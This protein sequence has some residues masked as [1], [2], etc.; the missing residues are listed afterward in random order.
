M[1]VSLAVVVWLLGEQTGF[2]PSNILQRLEWIAYDERVN[3]TLDGVKDEGVVIVDIDESSIQRI[4]HWP[5][6]R[7]TLAELTHKLFNDYDIQLLGLDMVFAEREGDALEER[8]QALVREFPQLPDRPTV[9]AGDDLFAE[10]LMN[11][12]VVTGF[13]FQQSASSL[14]STGLLSEPLMVLNA[15]EDYLQIPFLKPSRYT[16]NIETLQAGAWA[17]GFFDNPMVDNDGVIRRAPLVQLYEGELYPSLPLAMLG[18]VL[19]FPPVE[20]DIIE[21]GG[22]LQ[23]EGID[24]GGFYFPTD[25]RGG[26]LVPWSGP[27]EHYTYVSAADVLSGDADTDILNDAIV[28]LGTSAPGLMDLRSTPVGGVYPGV[29][30]QANLLS[31]MLQ[32]NFKQ[33]PGYS[34]AI[35]AL[36]ILAFGLLFTFLYPRFRA[37]AILVVSGLLLSLHLWLNLYAWNGG[38]VLPLASG[39]LLIVLLTGWHLAMNFLRESAEKRQVAEQFG[40]YI[41]PEL[42]SDIVK[43][44]EAQDMVGQEKELTVLFSD[45]RGFTSF[46]EQIPPAEL[47]DVMNRLLTP[48]TQAIHANRGTIDKYMGDAVMAFWGAPLDDPDHPLHAV[49]GALAMQDALDQINREFEAEG[50]QRLAMGIG[51]HT[52]VMNVGNMG[53]EFRM[54]YTVLGDNVNL[55]SRLEGLTKNYGVEILVSETTV[56]KLNETAHDFVFRTLDKVQVKGR[57]APVAIFELMGHRNEHLVEKAA[58]S[59][60]G[61]K[62]YQQQKFEKALRAFESHLKQ[63]PNDKLAQLYIERC[64]QYLE[65]PPPKDWDG[66]FVHTTK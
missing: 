5:W 62:L 24:L 14:P 61:I 16:A 23:L 45:V 3:R 18:T 65:T 19:G 17:G 13:Y 8:W 64:R 56:E 20:L 35:T 66:V 60:A 51:V 58:S 57:E 26:A 63:F 9:P 1:L 55:G 32:M 53:S 27:R 6:A 42:V 36:G 38:L 50:K 30:I 21:G 15:E 40:R 52:G 46:S 41:P 33:E 37:L 59:D 7:S 39:V 31:G 22:V 2:W 47:T 34:V 49:E 10:A 11:Y 25:P 54:A 4:G 12:P 48:V 43:T 44:P 29:E 28:L